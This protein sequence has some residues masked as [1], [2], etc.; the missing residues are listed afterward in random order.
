MVRNLEKQ[1][2]PVNMG[3]IPSCRGPSVIELES[4]KWLL[5]AWQRVKSLHIVQAPSG[6]AAF[7]HEIE[8]RQPRYCYAMI[9]SGRT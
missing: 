5:C 2:F 1:G 9:A 8:Y 7:D 6:A 4:V 3:G